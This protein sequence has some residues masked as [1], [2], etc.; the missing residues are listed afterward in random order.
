MTTRTLHRQLFRSHLQVMFVA[1][2]VM[3]AVW[4]GDKFNHGIYHRLIDLAS[5]PLLNS[6]PT[7]EQMQSTVDQLLRHRKQ[8]LVSLTESAEAAAVKAAAKAV[9]AAVRLGNM[10]KKG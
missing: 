4:T 5:F 2:G 8:K 9:Q 3:V 10:I 7:L 1:I 6:D